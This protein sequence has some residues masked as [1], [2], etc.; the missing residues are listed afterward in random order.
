MLVVTEGIS[1]GGIDQ[2]RQWLFCAYL[3]VWS[4]DMNRARVV[5]VPF[6]S[7]HCGPLI[8]MSDLDKIDYICDVINMPLPRGL[9]ERL[10]SIFTLG[11]FQVY[12]FGLDDMTCTTNYSIPQHHRKN[13]ALYDVRCG[14]EDH[15]AETAASIMVEGPQAGPVEGGDYFVP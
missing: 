12:L 8:H 7:S 6:C 1:G 15:G 14:C 9:N 13:C 5:R 4:G 3:S 2:R 10:F 11:S